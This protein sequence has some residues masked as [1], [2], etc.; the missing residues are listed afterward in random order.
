MPDVCYPIGIFAHKGPVSD[1]QFTA[2]VDQIEALPAQLRAA[3]DGLTDAQLD[4]PYREGGWTLRQVV[5]HLPDSHMN[6]Y[7]RTLWALS[8]DAPTIKPYDEAAVAALAGYAAPLSDSLDLLQALHHRW[9][10]VLRSLTPKQRTRT[11]VHPEDRTTNP[12]ARHA[13]TYAWHGRHHL[14]H[15]TTTTERMDWG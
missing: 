2:W 4:T 10:T 13:G 1:A 9:V 5:H 6:G 7:L 14:A 11:F 12:L 8:E 15:V 3:V